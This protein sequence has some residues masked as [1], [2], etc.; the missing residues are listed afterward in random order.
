MEYGKYR[1]KKPLRLEIA[2][3]PNFTRLTQT[4]EGVDSA[5]AALS[6]GNW[7][8]RLSYQGTVLSMGQFTIVDAAVS[9]LVS[10]IQDSMFRCRENLPAVRF[11]WQ[12]VEEASYY[13]LEAGLAPDLSGNLITR[14]TA[15]ASF[16]ESV[17]EAGT[18]YWRVKPIFSSIYEGSSVYSPVASFKIEQIDEPVKAVSADNLEGRDS[19]PVIAAA[20]V[21]NNFEDRGSSPATEAVPALVEMR[22]SSSVTMVLPEPAPEQKPEPVK[23]AKTANQPAPVFLPEVK[24]LLPAAEKKIQFEDL[25]KTRRIDF[26]WSPVNGAN[27]YIFTLYHKGDNGRRRRVIQT[28]PL[29]KTNWTL[30]NFA[31]LD[32]GTFIWQVEAVTINRNGKIEQRGNVTENTFIIDI[33]VSSVPEIEDIGV[34]YG[35]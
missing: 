3:A 2:A 31:L 28:E 1:A 26:S 33:P 4:V 13:V 5:N 25:R 20:T 23:A 27:A 8:W 17:P 35:N 34:L 12:P 22:I 18:W 9:T 15:V 11:E 32:R 16:I 21:A 7:H 10:P 29:K 24:N 19:S 30:D 6:A 14:Q